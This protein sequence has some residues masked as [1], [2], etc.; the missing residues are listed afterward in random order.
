VT[1]QYRALGHSGLT[2][3]T[4]A[5]G[6]MMFGAWGNPD[7][8][9]CHRMVDLALDGGITLFD[10]ADIY[11]NGVSEEIL[12]RAVAGRRDRVVL[13]TKCGNPMGDDPQ[14][15]GLSARWVTQACEDSLRRLGTDHIDLFQMHRPDPSVPIA[16]TVGAFDELVTSG[17]IRAYG[18]S[19]F[20]AGELRAARDA[21]SSQGFALPTTEQPPYSLL[22]RGIEDDVLPVCRELGLGLLVWAPLDGGWLTGKYRSSVVDE[23]SRAVRQAEHFDHRDDEIRAQKMARVEELASF[24]GDHGLTLTQLAL[25]FV[26]SEPCVSAALIGPRT[27]EQLEDLLAAGHCALPPEFTA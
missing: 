11:D 13:A 25:A 15:R 1:L 24:A 22:N 4:L 5:L 7:E 18:T 21:A 19:T 8:V 16:E 20:S 12:G 9:A 23:S 3:S 27:P 14:R 17:K 2:T 6:T 10:T 26:L